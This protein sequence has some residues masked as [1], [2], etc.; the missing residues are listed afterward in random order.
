MRTVQH[1]MRD[2]PDQPP[3]RFDTHQQ[4][5]SLASPENMLVAAILL[6]YQHV[7]QTTL[8]EDLA[9]EALSAQER[10]TLI[11]AEERIEREIVAFHTLQDQVRHVDIERIVEQVAV[12]LRPGLNPYRDLITWREQFHHQHI[13]QVAETSRSIF[14][15]RR[16]DEQQDTWLYELWLTLEL[17]HMLWQRLA[18]D[19]ES[20]HL[21]T[22][23]INFLFTWRD[24]R[25]RLSYQRR[26]DSVQGDLAGWEHAPVV[27]ATYRIE[28]EQPLRVVQEGM[29][30]WREPP[31][32]VSVYYLS[33]ETRMPHVRYPLNELLGDMNL[34][35]ASHGMLCLPYLPAGEDEQT[36]QRTMQ[37]NPQMYQSSAMR[38]AHITLCALPP[39]IEQ[40]T[41]QHR[42]EQLLEQASQYLP[43]RVPVACHGIQLDS[44][45]VNAT[46]TALSPYTTLC[47]KPH[48]GPS[49]FDL[50]NEKEHCLKDARLCH[51]I[52]QPIIPPFVIRS[53]T[54]DDLS[55]QS[56][57]LRA[58][59]DA[60][61]QQAE[62]RED[63]VHAEQIRH[64]IFLSVGRAVEQYVQLRGNT[65]SLEESY[66]EWIFGQ[67]WQQHAHCLAETTRRILLSAAYVWNEYKQTQLDDWA[68]PAIQYCR[69]LET[70]IKRRLHDYYPNPK[71]GGFIFPHNQVTLG[72]L[73]YMYQHKGQQDSKHNWSLCMTL[74]NQA[75]VQP[76]QFEEVIGRIVQEHVVTY[77]NRLAHGGPITQNV[78]QS[79]RT[80]IIGNRNKPG[81]LSWLAE[82]LPPKS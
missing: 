59:S 6:G 39:D 76:K 16:P 19:P 80:T 2:L 70:E 7:L 32:L 81:I 28:R 25:F 45:T 37:P 30:I 49:V 15:R 33:P 18:I 73:E 43:E 79:L 13:H 47:P 40:A 72:A 62:D 58:R 31:F 24:R 82:H 11:Q 57:N 50:V 75:R 21:A 4:Q 38:D 69:A 10:Q 63:E 20:L 67:H 23:E 44:E 55:Q 9:D 71:Q 5:R 8:Q 64:H 41:L 56:G 46:R 35:G 66:E 60:L 26:A 78:A 77:R 48:I 42:L 12:H 53:W 52:G 68:A 54:L 17:L 14:P 65:E 61:L 29:L 34:L 36:Y 51:A 27:S 1:T 74:V 22:D 3:L